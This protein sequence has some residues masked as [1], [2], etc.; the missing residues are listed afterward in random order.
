MARA[1]RAGGQHCD[2]SGCTGSYQVTFARLAM[3]WRS[4]ARADRSFNGHK[5][6]GN[7]GQARLGSAVS[8]IAVGTTPAVP[9]RP[10]ACWPAGRPVAG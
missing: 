7:Q 4:Q 10:A 1:D 3:P 9:P 8:I 6:G 5:A 2:G